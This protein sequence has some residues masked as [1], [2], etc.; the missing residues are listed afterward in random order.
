[1]AAQLSIE[2]CAA[3]GFKKLVTKYQ[4]AIVAYVPN[5]LLVAPSQVF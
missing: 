5:I 2:S 1:M 4:I 3:I